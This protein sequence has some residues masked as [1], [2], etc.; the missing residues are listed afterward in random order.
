MNFSAE[1]YLFVGSPE[2]LSPGSFLLNLTLSNSSSIVYQELHRLYFAFL[3]FPGS[4][5]NTIR[6]FADSTATGS[7]TIPLNQ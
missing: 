2:S 3:E 1:Q 7:L 4:Q 5:K 6:P